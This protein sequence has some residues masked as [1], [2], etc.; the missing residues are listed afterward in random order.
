MKRRRQGSRYISCMTVT[1][2]SLIIWTWQIFCATVTAP[3]NACKRH[4]RR[5]VG[6]MIAQFSQRVLAAWMQ[7]FF[8]ER[9]KCLYPS[10]PWSRSS[11]KNVTNLLAAIDT[12]VVTTTNLPTDSES[13]SWFDQASYIKITQELRNDIDY[14]DHLFLISEERLK[15]V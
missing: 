3:C 6:N 7:N 10:I 14:G 13:S 9:L 1:I 5:C 15:H 11:S 2:T 8:L 12:A 4:N